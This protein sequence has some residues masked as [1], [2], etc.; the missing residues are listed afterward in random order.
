MDLKDKMME[1]VEL[2]SVWNESGKE[3]RAKITKTVEA[4]AKAYAAILDGGPDKTVK[5]KIDK[6]F[7]SK[8]IKKA[9]DKKKKAK[10]HA[11]YM[12]ELKSLARYSHKIKKVVLSAY[13]QVGEAVAREVLGV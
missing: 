2:S 13:A 7:D 4:F 1:A 9:P 12:N 8:D 6:M 10:E 11:K 3:D 5:G